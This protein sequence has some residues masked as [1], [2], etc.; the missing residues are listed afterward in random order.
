[1]LYGPA[2]ITCTFFVPWG[3]ADGETPLGWC[4]TKNDCTSAPLIMARDYAP[5][6]R[7]GTRFE[8][9][10][11]KKAHRTRATRAGARGAEFLVK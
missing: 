3:T 8:N 11:E 9:L 1:M 5:Q 2:V 4:C 6:D 10:S 7:S